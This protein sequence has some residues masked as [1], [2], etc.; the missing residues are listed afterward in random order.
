MGR[1][2]AVAPSRTSR[3]GTLVSRTGTWQ[4]DAMA[5][6]SPSAGGMPI[7]LGAIGGAAV[8]FLFGQATPGF[9]IGLVLGIVIALLIW[10]R[11]R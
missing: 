5:K 1:D 3:N 9:L 7:A 6:S 8:G 2:R 11:G 4:G 10:W